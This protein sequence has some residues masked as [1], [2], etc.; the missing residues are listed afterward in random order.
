MN[1]SVA[2]TIPTAAT[3]DMPLL[4][5]GA[6]GEAVRFLQELLKL[7]YGYN[8]AVDAI[9]GPQTEA[10]VTDFQAKH[11]PL[12]VDKIVGK[13]TWRELSSHVGCC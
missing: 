11:P 13:N 8:I 9:F 5:S 6:R 3:I 7:R 2:G 12:V 10:A 1:T 4:K